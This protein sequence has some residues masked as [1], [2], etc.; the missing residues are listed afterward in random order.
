MTEMLL[1]FDIQQTNNVLVQGVQVAD[2]KTLVNCKTICGVDDLQTCSKDNVRQVQEIMH[3]NC[4]QMVETI[5]EKAEV[6]SW[7]VRI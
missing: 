4:H 1:L 5:A 7:L 6:F 3:P 2:S